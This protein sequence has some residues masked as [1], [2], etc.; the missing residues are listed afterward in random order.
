[1]QSTHTKRSLFYPIVILVLS[2]CFLFYKFLMQ[3][4]PS[5]ITNQMMHDFS[6]GGTELGN[7]AAAFFYTY[8]V[9]Q[10][11]VG[12]LLDKISI[13]ILSSSAI[14]ISAIGMY[15]FAFSQNIEQAVLS[16]C[17]MGIGAAFATIS[18]IKLTANWFS[19]S[20]FA[21]VSGFLATAAMI[22]AIF[23]QAP[24][25]W[26]VTK[27]GWRSAIEVCAYGGACVALVFLV[28]V[29]TRPNK[30]S[31]AN[32]S[33]KKIYFSDIMAIL[34]SKQNWL[35]TL[36]SGVSFAPVIVFGGLWGD[37]FISQAYEI[38]MTQ[39]A[40]LVSLIFVGLAFGGP[41]LGYLSDKYNT[42]K[43]VLLY[44]A[45]VS[46]ISSIL[47]IYV[48]NMPFGVLGAL[49]TLFGFSTGS[50]LLCFA[51]GKES[52]PIHL[53]ATVMSLINTGE[54]VIGSFTQ[55]LVGKVLDILHRNCMT[56]NTCSPH[57][58]LAKEF[59][60]AFVII[61]ICLIITIICALLIKEQ[62]KK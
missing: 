38:S 48:N 14:F 5:I 6:I 56:A 34:K 21:F 4:F 29:K 50:L 52:N 42:R 2:S 49:L 59:H 13:R 23:G 9:T 51:I 10:L 20:Q 16:R 54:A 27:I 39:S 41:I 57:K 62:V 44:G 30:T 37:P 19:A 46:L 31:V 25:S 7:L 18:Y 17:I 61:P 32:S 15:F 11:F 55:P 53:A 24:L 33:T 35:L 43:Q 8:L 40:F 47:I 12:I 28:V 22:G 26:M 60:I 3:V 1:M 58:F 36:Y 45:I